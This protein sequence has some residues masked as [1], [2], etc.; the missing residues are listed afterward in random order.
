[1]KRIITMILALSLLVCAAAGVHGLGPITASEEA[2]PWLGF[3]GEADPAGAASSREEILYVEEEPLEQ[4]ELGGAMGFPGSMA[5]TAGDYLNDGGRYPV[6][7]M[8]SFT[9]DDC[10]AESYELLYRQVIE[11]MGLPYTLSVPLDKLGQTGFI[12][13]SQLWEMLE[14]GVSVSCHC[15]K[16]DAMNKY[17]VWELD[18]MLRQWH[19][20]AELLGLG[21]VL[22]YSYCNGI[23]NEELLTAVKAHF[24]M[25]FTVESGINQM[26]YE[27]FFMKRVGLFS[28]KTQL[29]EIGKRDGTYLNANGTLVS[30]TPGQ[31]QT[32]KAIPVQEG[33]EYLL[34]CSAI[35]RGACYAV[36]NKAG[37]VLQKY[38]VPD[39]AT[40]ELLTEHKVR[41]PAGADHMVV[42]HNLQNY[43]A[44]QMTVKK[45]PDGATLHNA[46]RYMDQVAE[47]GGWLVFMTHAWYSGFNAEE[48]RELVAYIQDAGIPIVDVNDAIRLTGNVIEVGTFRKPLEYAASPY[49]VVSA[50]GRVYTN[51]MEIPDVPE[52]Y[53]SVRLSL[54][55]SRMLYQDRLIQ[56]NDPG[57][58]VSRAEDVSGCRAVLVT[59]WSYDPQTARGYQIYVITDADG[60]VLARHN[61]AVP[62]A[63]GGEY[64]DHQYIELPEGAAY[65]QIAGNIYHA[66]PELTKIYADG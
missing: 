31:R 51:S 25:G 4:E 54:M 41:I 50:D 33:E 58:L 15:F 8:V 5:G 30:A 47:E 9:D 37:K 38:N 29:L 60:N 49:F 43:G 44:V 66:R 26:P 21:E 3:T 13:Q 11:P 2:E 45:I 17:S 32:S 48:L 28:N 10:R 1:M 63:Q 61:A 16:E 35:W 23:W 40:G 22:S 20:E 53:E 7:A 59:G 12:D 52:N 42:S 39:T 24:R 64:L 36:Y 56:I 18:E 19:E 27:S 6:R 34:T 62:Y 65:I 55:E 46:K 57:Y 14:G